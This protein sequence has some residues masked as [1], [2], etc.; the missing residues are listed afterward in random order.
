ML[1]L[2]AV[3]AVPLTSAP[4]DFKENDLNVYPAALFGA[5]GDGVADDSAAIQRAIDAAAA[6]GGGSVHL[7][8]GKTYLLGVPLHLKA[9]VAVVSERARA[10]IVLAAGYTASA[11]IDA[12]QVA[13]VG[14]RNLAIR[15]A[16]RASVGLAV[17]IEGS[18]DVVLDNLHVEGIHA[19]TYDTE[20]GVASTALIRVTDSHRVL[21]GG[22]RVTQAYVGINVAGNSTHVTVDDC[23]VHDVTQFGVHVLGNATSHTEHLTVSRCRLERI[24]GTYPQVGYPIYITAGGNKQTLHKHRYVRAMDNTIIG[25][26]KAYGKGGNADLLAVYD[27]FDGICERNVLFFGGDAGLSTDRGRKMVLANNIVGHCNTVGINVWQ[28]DDVTV[29][30]NVVYNNYQNYDGGLSNEARGG[31]RTY[32]RTGFKAQNIVITGNRCFDDQATKTQDYGIYI[33]QRTKGVEIGANTL[34]GNKEGMFRAGYPASAVPENV[35]YS[36]VLTVD[37]LPVADYWEK[38]MIV[39]LRNPAPGQP[40]QWVCTLGG[41]PGTWQPVGASA[42]SAAITAAPSFVGQ[43]ALVSGAVYVATGIAAAA[44]WHKL[45]DLS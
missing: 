13:V 23:D 3:A 30:G 33:H 22:C 32:A 11:V 21:I 20:S 14:L 15:C 44:D 39:Q 17:Q 9:G 24:G 5:V 18:T 28:T 45:G 36:F 19:G 42:V 35:T 26:K 10:S 43:L 34:T 37:A 12:R 2:T 27:I 31:I 1:G 4:L 40:L 38:G 7:S 29:V 41:K 25:N 16:D 6:A 8:V